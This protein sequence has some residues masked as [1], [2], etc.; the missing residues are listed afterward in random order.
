MMAMILWI[1]ENESEDHIIYGRVL[2]KLTE[3]QRNVCGRQRES[4]LGLALKS[5]PSLS[6]IPL[7]CTTGTSA[8][9]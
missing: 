8:A 1:C 5:S 6:L 7:P 4:G 9:V 2:H 3:S